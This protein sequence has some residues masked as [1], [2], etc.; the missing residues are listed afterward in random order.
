MSLAAAR[1]PFHALPVKPGAPAR[2]AWG[3][4]GATDERGA[5]NLLTP[6]RVA[7]AALLV[8]SGKQ[9]RLDL[10]LDEPRQTFFSREPLR[11][12]VLELMPNV[13]D[14]RLDSFFPQAS[15]QWDA[16]SHYA[17]SVHG[18]YNGHTMAQAKTGRLSIDAMAGQGLAGRAVLA[19]VAGY[20]QRIGAPF[21][22][23]SPFVVSV[24]VLRATL[25][26]QG[27][28]LRTGD[29]LLVRTGWLGWF[30]GLADP[31]RQR[32]ADDSRDLFAFRLP[33]LGP[34][35]AM[36]EFLWD[37][38]V[39]M[40]AA[41]TPMVEVYPVV[42]ALAEPARFSIDDTMHSQVMALLGIPLG[43]FFVLDALAADCRTDARWEGFFTSAPLRL[44]GGI[45]SPP[46]VIV[47]K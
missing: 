13:L 21:H 26:A 25:A 42:A 5:L 39:A 27:T 43:E 31:D 4:Y 32:V 28:I 38:G 37:A 45:G 6:A 23:D 20:Q 1:P 33:G 12:A 47:F 34:A 29:L 16:L 10:P 17:H 44:R 15:T 7:D 35:R 11:H 2:S 19:D 40:V 14:D 22:P 46:N 9:F 18:F 36:A 24:D 41:D 30:L 3:L 8:R